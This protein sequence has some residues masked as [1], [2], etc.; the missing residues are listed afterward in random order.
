[1]PLCGT[2][3]SGK[4]KR[5]KRARIFPF[6]AAWGKAAGRGGPGA[7]GKGSGHMMDRSYQPPKP[8]A[9]PPNGPGLRRSGVRAV[10]IGGTVHRDLSRRPAARSGTGRSPG[11][12]RPT[13]RGYRSTAW[14]MSPVS[15]SRGSGRRHRRLGPCVRGAD[16]N[17]ALPLC[18]SLDLAIALE[19]P[20]RRRELIA[21]GRRSAAGGVRAPSAGREAGRRCG[22][23]FSSSVIMADLTTATSWSRAA[24]RSCRFGGVRMLALRSFGT[25]GGAARIGPP[26]P[27][28]P[29]DGA[30][31]PPRP[32]RRGSGVSV[33]QTRL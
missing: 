3:H 15:R 22:M 24:A 25:F 7:R 32:S 21:A 18:R 33:R 26:T 4:K 11:K 13:R 5:A 29:A 9:V 20:R 27:R 17:V 14:F 19:R 2:P 8:P 30:G 16:R 6:P 23:S 12:T 28:G 31:R 10:R 1:M